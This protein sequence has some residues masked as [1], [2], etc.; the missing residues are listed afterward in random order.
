MPVRLVLASASPSRRALLSRAG[1]EPTV[2]VSDVDEEAVV[3]QARTSYPD[4]APGE[5]ALLLARAKAEDV[6]SALRGANAPHDHLVLGC[7]SVLELAG[8]V[9]GKPGSAPVAVQRWQ[10][11]RGRAGVLHTGHWL[12][13]DRVD[14]S[15]GTVGATA[16]TVVRFADVTDAEIDAYVATGEPLHVAGA[17][18]LEGRSAPYIEG[19]E[20]DPS[21][22]MG[23]SLPLLR[24]LLADV[25]LTFPDLTDPV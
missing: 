20:G 2:Y 23:L 24:H 16:E 10:Q 17:F 4:L 15:R 21:N 11:M 3:A 14:G 6:A 7:D 13:D 9:L 19:I 1:V 12:V 18:T 5:L 8:E 22:V 25:G